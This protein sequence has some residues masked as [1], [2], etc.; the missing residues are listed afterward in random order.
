LVCSVNIIVTFEYGFII[1]AALP[2]ALGLNLFITICLPQYASFT[3]KLSI[4]YWKLFSAL[5]TA[6]EIVFLTSFEILFSEK[7]KSLIA[8]STFFS[9]YRF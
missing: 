9:Y 5:A 3:I 8:T 1:S 6:E 2:F 4:S 7:D